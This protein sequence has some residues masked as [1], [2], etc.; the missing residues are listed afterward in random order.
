MEGRDVT[1]AQLSERCTRL[2][3]AL[4]ALATCLEQDVDAR[5]VYDD[6]ETMRGM[7]PEYLVERLLYPEHFGVDDAGLGVA[8]RIDR[9]RDG[10]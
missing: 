3:A 9:A 4:A 10:K 8:D 7:G 6:S 1:E 2:E 5:L